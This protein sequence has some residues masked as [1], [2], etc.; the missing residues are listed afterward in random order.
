MREIVF[1]TETT[2]LD[3]RRGDRLIEIGCI[4][5]VNRIPTGREF[6]RYINPE[7]DVPAEAEAVHGLSTQFLLDKPLFADVAQ[8]FLDFIAG[9]TLVAHNAVFDIGFLNAELER[10]GHPTT[11]SMSRVVDTLQLARRKH[12]AGPNSLDALCKRYGIDNSKRIKHGALMDSLLL[13]DV[14]VELL[15]ERQASLVLGGERASAARDATVGAT[16]L[17]GPRPVPLA[18]RLTDEMIAAHRAFVET[19]GPKA[20]WKR[21]FAPDE[22]T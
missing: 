2:G 17:R 19:L 4:E 16:A 21:Y 12:P 13:A 18:A 20:I 6:H 11:I 1:D 7:R 3:P 9:D 14:Y 22:A 8:E 10:W 15:G 5:I